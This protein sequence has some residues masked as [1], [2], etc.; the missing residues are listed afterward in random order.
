MLQNNGSITL[1]FWVNF[2]EYLS[3]K[4]DA[5]AISKCSYQ[6]RVLNWFWLLLNQRCFRSGTVT[7]LKT[8]WISA[9]S[10][11]CTGFNINQNYK[12]INNISDPYQERVSISQVHLPMSC[13]V[14][15]NHLNVPLLTHLG[16]I[17]QDQWVIGKLSSTSSVSQVV[18]SSTFLVSVGTRG[19]RVTSNSTGTE[20]DFKIEINLFNKRG[21]C[22]AELIFMTKFFGVRNYKQKRQNFEPKWNSSGGKLCYVKKATRFNRNN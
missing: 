4:N 21:V 19:C 10:W 7:I 20:R 1:K 18:F 2:R 22:F 8:F 9:E 11:F 5:S 12:A 6:K 3:I 16:V 13:C 17:S 15:R 14:W